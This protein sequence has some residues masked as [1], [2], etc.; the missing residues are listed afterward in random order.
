MESLNNEHHFTLHRLII[1]FNLC[2]VSLGMALTG[3]AST[4]EWLDW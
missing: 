2:C 3:I 1:K 4:F